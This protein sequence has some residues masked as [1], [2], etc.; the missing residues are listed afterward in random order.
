MFIGIKCAKP[1]TGIIFL[2]EVCV[3]FKPYDK[4]CKQKRVA[5]NIFIQEYIMI[6]FNVSWTF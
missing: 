6:T 3:Y 1:L 4:T 5:I 2:K